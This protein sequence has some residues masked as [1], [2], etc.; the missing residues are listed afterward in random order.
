[1]AVTTGVGIAAGN[2]EFWPGNYGQSN[3][4]NI[5]GASAATYDFGDGGASAGVGHG[6]MQIHNFAAGHTILSVTHC[7]NNN[8][9]PALG[10][11]NNPGSSSDP[12]W[13]FTYNAP[14]FSTKNL[15]VLARLGETPA[16]IL[17]GSL[18]A[19]HI[20]PKS[21]TIRSG[22]RAGF[23]VRAK[24]ASAY[25][26]RRNGVWIQGATC[27]SLDLNPAGLDDAGTYDVLVYGSGTAYLT[28]ESALLT[29]RPLGTIFQ[30][31]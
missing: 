9:V 29:V 27:S 28:S 11:G 1:M 18:P 20:N 25:Q 7:G 2:I 31:K 19:I 10:I 22:Q 5:P 3:D 12:D 15:Y 14:A 30:L 16:G 24:G 4:K 23:Y 6:S 26:W 21:Q 8:T 13:T 17:T